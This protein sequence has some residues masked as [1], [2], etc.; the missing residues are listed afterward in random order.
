MKSDPKRVLVWKQLNYRKMPEK[1]KRQLQQEVRLL[2]ELDHPNVVKYAGKINDTRMSL[3]YLIMEFCDGGDLGDYLSRTVK[4]GHYLPEDDILRLFSQLVSAL[5]YCH[6]RPNGRVLHRDLKPQ[7][8]FLAD[9]NVNVKLGDFGLAKLMHPTQL[10]AETHVGTPYYMSPEVLGKSHYD[11]KSDIWSLGCLLYEMTMGLPPFGRAKTYDQLRLMVQKGDIPPFPTGRYSHHLFELAKEMLS[12]QPSKRPSAA[13]L[14]NHPLVRMSNALAELKRVKETLMHSTVELDTKN[15]ELEKLKASLQRSRHR[16]HEYAQILHGS[17]STTTLLGGTDTLTSSSGGDASQQ[18]HQSQ[19]SPKSGSGMARRASHRSPPRSINRPP[20]SHRRRSTGEVIQ[21]HSESD[22]GE[23]TARPVTSPSVGG[24]QPGTPRGIPVSSKD[25]IGTGRQTPHITPIYRQDPTS[26]GTDLSTVSSTRESRSSITPRSSHVDSRFDVHG[27]RHSSATASGS[28]SYQ[29]HTIDRMA[30][31]RARWSVQAGDEV[32][33]DIRA[34]TVKMRPQTARNANSI[35]EYEAYRDGDDLHYGAQQHG[36][37]PR[38]SSVSPRA[39]HTSTPSTEVGVGRGGHTGTGITGGSS[40]RRPI[41]SIRSESPPSFASIPSYLNKDEDNR[42]T[43]DEGAEAH[44]LQRKHPTPTQS[45]LT[46]LGSPVWSTPTPPTETT[47]RSSSDLRSGPQNHAQTSLGRRPSMR[48]R[49]RWG[50][51]GSHEVTGS[52]TGMVSALATGSVSS[53]GSGSGTRSKRPSCG[54]PVDGSSLQLISQDH[55][56]ANRDGGAEV[57]ESA[58][59]YPRP[60]T[61]TSDQGSTGHFAPVMVLPG[62]NHRS[63][64]DSASHFRNMGDG[65]ERGDKLN[66]QHR[67]TVN[68]YDTSRPMTC[69][70]SRLIVGGGFDTG[71]GIYSSEH[72]GVDCESES[73]NE[74]GYYGW[75]R[76]EGLSE[77]G[78]TVVPPGSV[79]SGP[80]LSSTRD[81]QGHHVDQLTDGMTRLSTGGR[82]RGMTNPRTSRTT[83]TGTGTSIYRLQDPKPREKD[84]NQ[85]QSKQSSSRRNL[86]LEKRFTSSEGGGGHSQETPHSSAT[87]SHHLA[88]GSQGY[89][90]PQSRTGTPDQT[91]STSHRASS[92]GT[93]PLVVGSGVIRGP[94]SHSMASNGDRGRR[95]TPQLSDVSRDRRVPDDLGSHT[96]HSGY[97]YGSDEITHNDSDHLSRFASP[98][99]EAQQRSRTPPLAPTRPSQRGSGG[100]RQSGGHTGTA[101]KGAS[102][103]T[104]RYDQPRNRYDD[105]NE[106]T[107]ARTAVDDRMERRSIRREYGVR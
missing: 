25:Y 45:N 78:D 7:N 31:D 83:G 63:S 17:K 44:H 79:S 58:H 85:P 86:E 62:H 73:R 103:T 77:G 98:P 1:E 54:S 19:H 68:S 76:S 27:S 96:S 39:A 46:Q 101:G 56:G 97:R 43:R 24:F 90:R 66:P 40:V 107:N 2:Q 47:P 57:N 3:L 23:D 36:E 22:N 32:T 74:G 13:E 87:S 93:K 89:R 91:H 35:A 81:V 82:D 6:D 75:S 84:S 88:G 95:F 70:T 34:A 50:S 94:P 41:T 106:P 65:G 4:K 9:D 60:S 12:H 49:E 55:T 5:R 71:S 61:G 105:E 53:G 51:S 59:R 28:G 52:L 20:S 69:R 64:V 100:Y 11:E 26:L 33:R 99:S 38:S 92:Y 10:L 18:S 30:S 42:S 102:F 14:Q 67:K 16:E 21:S 8:I 48:S 72:A 37:R 104:K 80:S 29:P 15:K